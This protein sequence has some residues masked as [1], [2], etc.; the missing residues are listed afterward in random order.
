MC[1]I[2]GIVS[3]KPI[4][5]IHG[6]LDVML[7]AQA[8]RGPDDEGVRIFNP[9]CSESSP[10]VALGNRR[11]AIIDLSPSGHQ[12]M[13]SPDGRICVTFNGEIYNFRALRKE[14]EAGDCKFRS[15][16]DTEVLLHGY[17]RWGI[18]RLLDRLDGM[19]A[20][21]VWDQ[22]KRRLVLARDR[23][24][25][26]PLYYSWDGARLVFASELRSL[27]AAN[28]VE[29]SIQPAAVRAFLAFGSVPAPL[30]IVRGISTLPPANYLTLG[31]G[32]L[33][34][35]RYWQL[36][37]QEDPDIT[38]VRAIEEMGRL[39]YES[40]QSR[41]ISDVPLGVFLSGGLDSSTIVG[42]MREASPS[43]RI[44]TFA[45][46]FQESEYS[47]GPFAQHVAQRFNTEHTERQISAGEV[48][49]ELPK[50]IQA[51]DQPTIDG[52]N[53]YFISKITRESGTVVALC[54]I[55]AD[56]LLGGYRQFIDVARL[57]RI[58][59]RLTSIPGGAALASGMLRWA[60]S[61]R[62]VAK[63]RTQLRQQYSCE[64]SYLAVRGLMLGE[65]LAR[66]IPKE[67]DGEADGF[68]AVEYLR[69]FSDSS[70]Q[71][72]RNRVSLL[73]LSVYMHNQLLRDTDVMSM[74]HSLEVRVPFLDHRLVEFIATVPASVKF[75]APPK[76][77]LRKLM[78]TRLPPEIVSRPKFGFTFPIERWLKIEWRETAEAVF[79]KP[80]P[81]GL[82]NRVGA[83]SLWR[84][85]LNGRSHWSQVWAL[86]VLQR[87]YEDAFRSQGQM[88]HVPHGLTVV[89]RAVSALHPPSPV[90]MSA[91]RR[92]SEQRKPTIIGI[93][94]S[95]D[96]HGGI[97]RACRHMA[98]A[99][100][101]LGR[102]GGEQ[103]RLFS[104]NDSRG[105]HEMKIDSISFS[106]T[107]FA[108]NKARLA[109]AVMCAAP[110]TRLAYIGHANLA[111]LGLCMRMLNPSMHYQ[112]ATYGIE[113]WQPL[114]KLNGMALRSANKVTS[115]SEFTREQVLDL[116]KVESTKAVL[117]PLALDPAFYASSREQVAVLGNGSSNCTILT[118]GR[119]SIHDQ[120]KGI[121][122]VI[123]AL[124]KV[125]EK[126]PNVRYVVVGDGDDRSRLERLAD[127]TGV[128][129]RVFFMPQSTDRKLAEYYRAC[130]IFVMPSSKEGFGLVF[131]E[132]MAFGKPVIGGNFGGTPDLIK[133]GVNGFLV[134][135]NDPDALAGRITLLLASP[136]LRAFMGE[137]GRRMVAEKYT[138]E[139][140][141]RGVE[142]VLN[143]RG[144][145]QEAD[146]GVCN[147]PQ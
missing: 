32:H 42:L 128:R 57:A 72:I 129:E 95:L 7:A 76:G 73:E 1:G 112:V 50:I 102:K 127:A 64:A 37:F 61:D 9:D 113:V 135:C 77:L 94:G 27:L 90:A 140:F 91:E 17:R 85:F 114:S 67:V 13:C 89:D 38:E 132:A 126:I 80:G 62:R 68:E 78:K 93:F 51:M 75:A 144:A 3:L 26:K 100:V 121:D 4:A 105:L 106:F 101:T 65:M 133:D 110:A 118:I 60:G 98:A 134:K 54:G 79:E 86:V 46:T 136:E 109:A 131:L 88:S 130:D 82:I 20:F 59:S 29:R 70:V 49:T 16:T 56:E 48:L 10:C 97:E 120:Y 63:L 137:A 36:S 81:D 71:D 84:E 40:V 52:I 8:H 35:R 87:W 139:H 19:F 104:L 41:L 25:E 115:I 142:D 30:T 145:V 34:L 33:Q 124:P 15:N 58:W 12:P 125:I 39:L 31:D 147:F 117:L 22:D 44:R 138:F 23:L 43:A 47:E 146:R 103:Y 6:T 141:V 66:L 92:K 122:T 11:L 99:M 123:R 18:E 28:L 83:A 53:T 2:A 45:A 24:G 108:R 14:L 69:T 55:G 74:A 143:G 119:T 107:G 116:Q 111:P 96:E 21:A 5:G